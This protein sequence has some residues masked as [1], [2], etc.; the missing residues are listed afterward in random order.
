ME[1]T[2]NAQPAATPDN[3]KTIAILSYITIIGWIVALV[4]HGSNK[5]S[6]GAYHLRQGLGIMIL[7][8]ATTIIRI[9]LMFIPFIGW[10]IGLCI[11]LGL[12]TLWILGLV[13]A[14]N[15][16]EK[17]MPLVGGLFQT[18]FANFAK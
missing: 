10:G 6:L 5:T 4:M 15:A 13:A 9:P 16:E 17:P 1:N 14:V 18:W 11:S 7:A 8:I 3:G 2:N 12:L